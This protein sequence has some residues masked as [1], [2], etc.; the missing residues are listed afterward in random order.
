[1]RPKF[2]LAD[3]IRLFGTGLAAR[4]SLT[5]LQQRVLGKIANCR[6]AA[7]GGHEEACDTCGTIRYSYNSCGDRHCPKCQAAKQAFWID[8]LMQRT[9]PVKHYHIIF[10]V[11]HQL[12]GLCLH[13]Q[14]LYYNHCSLP[15][16]I[17]FV[18]SDTRITGWKAAPWRS[19]I[20]GD[21]IPIG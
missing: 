12:N 1:M 7:L 8:D 16:G 9:L 5:L 21:S 17:P 10:T 20:P 6:T 13:N 18:H 14:G 2:E 3:A 11:P 19:C 4:G 15:Y